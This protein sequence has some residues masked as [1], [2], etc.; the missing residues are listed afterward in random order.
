MAKVQDIGLSQL[1][2]LNKI[3]RP[4]LRRRLQITVKGDDDPSTS[5]ASDRQTVKNV[6]GNT[7][8]LHVK[9]GGQN[10]WKSRKG[11]DGASAGVRYELDDK[12]DGS[13]RWAVG[14][15]GTQAQAP[16]SFWV[17]DNMGTRISRKRSP[18]RRRRGRRRNCTEHA[19]LA[20]AMCRA[21]GCGR[22]ASACLRG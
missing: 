9:A 18:R 20:A 5:F 21:A 11:Q 7:F 10:P 16:R 1:V 4:T 8:E 17:H 3:L 22:T 12:L 15:E 19:V 6:K 2:R 13:T 14:R